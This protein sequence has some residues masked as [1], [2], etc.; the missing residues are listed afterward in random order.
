MA[1][2]Q[3]GDVVHLTVEAY[4]RLVHGGRGVCGITKAIGLDRLGIVREV[5]GDRCS[6]EWEELVT[7]SSPQSCLRLAAPAD[8]SAGS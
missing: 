1:K 5:D 8:P 7:Y 3:V 6:V 4:N 2:F